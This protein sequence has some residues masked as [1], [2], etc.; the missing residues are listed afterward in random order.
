[1]RIAVTDQPVSPAYPPPWGASELTDSSPFHLLELL[2]TTDGETRIVTQSSE[3]HRIGT[4]AFDDLHREESYGKWSAY[5]QRKLETLLFA[6]ELERW[7][8]DSGLTETK[9]SP[10]TPDMPTP[11]CS[12][13]A[14]ANRDRG[15]GTR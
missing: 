3:A 2:V 14:P 9:A 1:M 7:L 13:V 5:G 8:E 4:I 10:V 6:Y 15:S 12:I 11:I